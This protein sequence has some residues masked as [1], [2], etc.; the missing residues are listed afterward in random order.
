MNKTDRLHHIVKLL[1]VRRRIT[2]A[3]LQAETGASRATLMRDLAWLR[4]ELGHP[5][6]WDRETGCYLWR[7]SE[8]AGEQPEEM[9]GLWRCHFDEAAVPRLIRL[10]ITREEVLPVRGCRSMCGAH[11]S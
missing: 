3:E 1:R 6:H 11:S 7:E 9:A 5:I 4:D 2:R 8:R 10:H